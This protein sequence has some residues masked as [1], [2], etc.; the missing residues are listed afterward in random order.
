MEF[1]DAMNLFT[2]VQ[3]HELRDFAFCDTEVTFTLGKN[4]IASGYFSSGKSEVN[5]WNIETPTVFTGKQADQLRKVAN[6]GSL[7]RNDGWS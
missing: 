3:K 5:I 4:E 2:K 1:E 6:I 7:Q